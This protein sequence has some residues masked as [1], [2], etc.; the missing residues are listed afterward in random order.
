MKLHML[1]VEG[2]ELGSA[3]SI[4]DCLTLAWEADATLLAIP[5]VRFGADFWRLETRLLG[6]FIQ[7]FATYRIDL[8]FVG[9]LS[10]PLERSEA[11]RA[12]VR[13]AQGS[14]QLRFVRDLAELKQ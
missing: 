4:G 7:K 8:A 12:F 14:R 3:E 9:D 6:E 10:G 1:E 5:V 11:F 13:E 2:A